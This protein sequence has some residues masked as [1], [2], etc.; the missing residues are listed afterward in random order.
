MIQPI[1]NCYFVSVDKDEIY[2]SKFVDC[3]YSLGLDTYPQI[4][5]HVCNIRAYPLYKPL[6]DISEDDIAKLFEKE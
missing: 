3:S 4:E 1:R 6:E 2:V 5:G